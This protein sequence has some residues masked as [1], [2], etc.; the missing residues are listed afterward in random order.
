VSEV[1]Q[2]TGEELPRLPRGRHGLPREFVT[3]NQRE[4]LTA[5]TI[6]AVAENGLPETT[7]SQIVA[8]A[9]VSRR[10]FYGYFSS[11]EECY[12][13]AFE[14]V[15]AHLEA[16]MREAAAGEERWPRRVRAELGAMLDVFAANPDLA[17][18]VLVAPIRS[19]GEP[20]ERHRVL[21]GRLVALLSDGRPEPP[22]TR[23]PT[24]AVEST[25]TAG[26]ATVIASKVEAG[27]GEQVEALL[28]DL[29][30]LTLTPYLGRK[31]AVAEARRT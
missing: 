12:L 27:E 8:A 21:L 25:M 1:E 18:L 3:R 9:G 29:L 4:R 5:G 22:K 20:A 2:G 23:E 28:P 14:A 15:A 17:R 24:E 19:G 31:R 30:E 11:K 10:T 13:D 16:V 26:L 6:A 7:V